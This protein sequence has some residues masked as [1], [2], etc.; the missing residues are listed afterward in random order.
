M[1]KLHELLASEADAETQMKTAINVMAQLFSKRTDAFF[2]YE[3]RLE[4]FDED[5]K[6]EEDLAKERKELIHTVPAKLDELRDPCV[7]YFDIAFQKESMN[8]SA[9]ADIVLYENDN[10]RETLTI[11]TDVPVT[12]LLF[13]ERRLSK[14]SEAYQAIPTLEAGFSWDEDDTKADGIFRVER[15][16]IKEKTQKVPKS[17][18]LYEATKE[19]PAQIEKWNEDRIIG[20]F[21]RR[22][23][24]GMLKERRKI[25]LLKRFEI[26]LDAVKRARAR[27]NDIEVNVEGIGDKIFDF[28]N[29]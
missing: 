20:R 10:S 5:R 28:L 1:G 2:G 3:R 25:E 17:K 26:L 22:V 27:A 19:H 9:R 13:L 29:K 11:A 6:A 16:E 21:V 14:V 7:R 18:I 8:Q 12:F 24:S 15:D 23:W 4:M